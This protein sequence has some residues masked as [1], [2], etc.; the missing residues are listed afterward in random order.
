M[1]GDIFDDGEIDQQGQM[2][3][4]D[5]I[6]N[7]G[8][9]CADFVTIPQKERNETGFV[10]LL[11]QGATCY[12][13]SLVQTLFMT[14]QF[15]KL[16][17]ELDISQSDNIDIKNNYLDN[18]NKWEILIEMQKLFAEMKY[19]DKQAASTEKMTRSFGWENNESV[20]QQDIQEA[21]RVLIDVV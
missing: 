10:G 15:Q 1:F 8:Q 3:D 7:K 6:H 14:P 13:N 12:L 18:L 4:F 16:I 5:K 2:Y 9:N 20:E 19:V 17:L 21:M 11:N